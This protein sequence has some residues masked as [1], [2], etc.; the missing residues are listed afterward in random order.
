MTEKIKNVWELNNENQR[1]VSNVNES[2]S[3]IAAVS[4]ELSSSMTEMENHLRDSTD[5]MNKV[6][7]DLKKTVEPVVVIEEML[8]TTVKQM[9][10]MA[11]DPF[12]HLKSQEFA[13]YLKSAVVA[14]N[15]W[16]DNL[17]KMVDGGVLM[18]LQLDAT[19]CGFGH[20]YYAIKPKLPAAIPI[21]RGLDEKHK[22][23]HQYGEEVTHALKSG[24]HQKAQQIYGEAVVYSRELIA[25]LEAL[26]R[27]AGA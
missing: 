6:S 2:V 8:D 10:S 1:H 4:Q 7:V 12:F 13:Q 15:T 20:F 19:K 18:P 24:N 26:Q 27:I 16:L 23:F 21:W 9:G 3:S 11:E 17:K 5:F 25:D 22:R 14:H